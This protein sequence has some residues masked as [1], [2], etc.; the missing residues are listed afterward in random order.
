MGWTERTVRH[1]Q[2]MGEGSARMR[3]PGRG[4]G[5]WAAKERVWAPRF[6]LVAEEKRRREKK[7]VEK[8]GEGEKGIIGISIIWSAKKS[9]FTTQFKKEIY[10]A[11]R[12][13]HGAKA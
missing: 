11:G 5:G 10:S 4:M 12:A 9:C 13:T 3:S 1:Y 2:H 6:A 7:R 8:K